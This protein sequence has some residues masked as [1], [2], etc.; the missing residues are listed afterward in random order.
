MGCRE[1]GCWENGLLGKQIWENVRYLTTLYN[2][3]LFFLKLI[4]TITIKKENV[5]FFFSGTL[6]PQLLQKISCLCHIVKNNTIVKKHGFQFSKV[7]VSQQIS[8]FRS[9]VNFAI[10]DIFSFKRNRFIYRNRILKG[11]F[12]IKPTPKF[13][14]IFSI[15]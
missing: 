8:F 12:Q 7:S 9:P 2:I 14:N 4:R 13:F 3:F 5:H 10:M 15:V 1:N 11:G 6:K